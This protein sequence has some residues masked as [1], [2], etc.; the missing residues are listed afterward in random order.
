MLWQDFILP[1]HSM[2]TRHGI[3]QVRGFKRILH[4]SQFQSFLEEHPQAQRRWN[5]L[6]PIL[7]RTI[8]TEAAAD[9]FKISERTIRRWK[10][11]YDSDHWYSLLPK[12]RRPKTAPRTKAPLWMYERVK[13]I[14]NSHLAW[15]APKIFHYIRQNDPLD[16]HI[17]QRTVSRILAVGLK[18]NDIEPRVK[19]KALVHHRRDVRGRTIKRIKNSTDPASAPG[20]RVHCD[21]VIVQIFLAAKGVLRKLY[22]S[23]T[24]DRF[25]KIGMVVAGEHLVPGLTIASH[26]A[27]QKILG[28]LIQEKINDNGSENLGACIE[29]Y[30]GENIVQLFTYPHAP[31]QNSV[32]ERFNRTFQEECLLGRRIDLTQPIEIIQEQIN[33]W[34]VEYNTERPHEGIDNMTPIRKLVTWK[35]QQLPKER[36]ADPLCGHMLWRGTRIPELK[37]EVE[38]LG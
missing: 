35:F 29:F 7:D 26:Q 1:P 18:K 24:I 25:S 5:V 17:K 13:E 2:R 19:L 4:A 14:A 15:G 8:T 12:S 20:E 23:N 11:D 10:D 16:R 6:R 34:L 30:E 3:T 28:E 9:V 27:L 32:A 33:A 22:F 38:H 36:Q 21:G 31:K 37:N